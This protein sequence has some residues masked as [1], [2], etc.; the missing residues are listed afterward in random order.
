MGHQGRA[1]G[2]H[3][4][5]RGEGVRRAARP[6]AARVAGVRLH[7]APG[8]HEVHAAA[9]VEGCEQ[10]QCQHL[11]GRAYT[12]SAP[13]GVQTHCQHL[14]HTCWGVQTHCQHLVHTCRGC[15]QTHC[16]HLWRG[17]SKH[18]VSTWS[19]PVGRANTLLSPVGRANTLLS[20]GPYLWGVQTHCYHLWGVQTHCQHL[21][22]RAYTLSAPDPHL[23]GRA[24]TLSAPVGRA[25]TLSAPVGACIHTVS[26]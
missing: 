8:R 25:N 2:A 13:V 11:W 7:R 3:G 14:V 12:L 19:I 15:E 5:G 20:P 22:G 10:T 9:P 21:W 16:Q 6:L 26:T 1:D 23:L 24:H 4:G 17:A 18:T